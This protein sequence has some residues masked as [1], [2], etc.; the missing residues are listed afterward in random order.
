M[1]LITMEWLTENFQYHVT[2]CFESPGLPNLGIV[3][4]KTKQWPHSTKDS[5]KVTS[6]D[7]ID[8]RNENHLIQ[9][10]SYFQGCIKFD[11]K[12]KDGFIE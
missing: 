5:L 8:N 2:F 10:C 11:L 1:A 6:S 9:T 7:V 3:V 12:A 4:R